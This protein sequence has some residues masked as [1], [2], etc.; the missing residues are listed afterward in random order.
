MKLKSL[1]I[2]LLFL[3]NF[4]FLK[5]SFLN[6]GSCLEVFSRKVSVKAAINQGKPSVKP[7]SG[8]FKRKQSDVQSQLYSF[9]SVPSNREKVKN[10][11]RAL[12][13]GHYHNACVYY[14][15]EALR[16]VGVNLP[17]SVNHTGRPG[18]DRFKHRSLTQHLLK[19][20]WKIEKDMT[21]L[22][23]GDVCF[24]TNGSLGAP[25]HAYIFMGWVKQGSYDYAYICDNQVYDYGSTYHKRNI[26]I[27]IPEKEAFAYFMYKPVK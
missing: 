21:K 7:Q 19:M 15:S 20:G 24:T 16:H 6:E 10:H 8:T 18:K 17:K 9:L 25:T 2:L 5:L 13:R 27:A 3:S 14:T 1:L 11:V 4:V 22:M 23:P 12:N 26:R